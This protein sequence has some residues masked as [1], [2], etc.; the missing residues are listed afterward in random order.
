MRYYSD[1]WATTS[2]STTTTTATTKTAA[3]PIGNFSLAKLLAL[4]LPIVVVTILYTLFKPNDAKAATVLIVTDSG[5]GTGC[6]LT[7]DGYILTNRHVIAG[8]ST[9]TVYFD[10][11]SAK[12]IKLSATV[13][14]KGEASATPANT[15]PEFLKQL[16]NDFAILK[17]QA[18]KLA[19]FTIADDTTFNK[20][21]K[22]T[23]I[24]YGKTMIDGSGDKTPSQDMPTGTI[25]AFLPSDTEQRLIIHTC[26]IQKGFSGGPLIDER[27]RLIGINT[28]S[29]PDDIGNN[30]QVAIPI[31]TFRGIINS[32]KQGKQ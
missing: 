14:Q 20:G 24:G 26:T 13:S 5:S 32:V 15:I 1:N 12:P 29:T 31:N 25:S 6:V 30:K 22:V 10:S 28:A 11:G 2:S 7:A 17:V 3:K 16:P 21:A 18:D 27:G 23:A 4:L 8:A 19:H 9:I